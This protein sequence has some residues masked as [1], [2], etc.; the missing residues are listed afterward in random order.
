MRLIRLLGALSLT[1]L[2]LLPGALA[3]QPGITQP[4]QRSASGQPDSYVMNFRDASIRDVAEQVSEVTGRTLILDPSVTGT[5][6]VIAADP[7]DPEGVWEFFQ[8][9]LRVNGFVA[10][11]SGDVWRVVPQ[12]NG[13]QSAGMS[14]GSAGA[15]DLVTRLIPLRNLS[16]ESAQRVLRPLVNTAGSLESLANPNSIIVTDYADNVSRIVELARQIDSGQGA[17][18]ATVT[19]KYASVSDVGPILERVSGGDAGGGVP[20]RIAVDARS[21]TVLVRGSPSAIDEIRRVAQALDIPGGVQPVTRVFRLS[22]SDAEFVTGILRGLNG[23]ADAPTN[24]VARSL[25]A[26]PAGGQSTSMA[27]P[28]NGAGFASSLGIDNQASA[29]AAPP[30]ASGGGS[31]E[32]S[33][34]PAVEINAVVVRGMPGAVAEVEALI[35]DLD[36]RR[37]QVL[38]EAAIVEIQGDVADALGVQLGLGD[39]PPEGAFAASS[40][41]TAGPSLRNI[42]TALGEP[43]A[44]GL[45]PEGLTFGASSGD[46]FNI[47]VQALSQSSKANLLSTPSLTTLDNQPAEIVVGQNVPFRTGSF[48]TS[49]NS[50]DPFTTIER[51]D[52]GITLQIVP[53]LYDGDVIRLEVAQEVSSLVNSNVLGAADLITNRRSIKTTVLADNGETIVLGGLITDDRISTEG[54]IPILGDLPFV[55]GLF[56][57]E[58][59][60]QTRRTLFVFLRPTIL[61]TPEDARKAAQR[62]YDRL[63]EHETGGDRQGIFLVPPPPRLESEINGIY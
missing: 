47:L 36:I 42:L 23:G 25:S 15:P 45:A 1:S 32:L 41:S 37:P 10:V 59:Q 21:N 9:A 4:G 49:G 30:I 35:K 57:S 16:A 54:K 51:Q 19:L 40:F 7:L 58:R 6:T 5:V 61:R 44:I 48:A 18:I 39:G 20:S 28:S 63:R 34:Q 55:G 46:G 26:R 50:R 29:S 33:I 11:K 60:N 43:V 22:N 38:V 2:A 13:V 8:S 52:V 27:T 12:A 17:E 24:P 53:R 14:R 62:D 56:G 3:Q 31:T